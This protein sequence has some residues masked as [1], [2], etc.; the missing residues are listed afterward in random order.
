MHL[1]VFHQALKLS[2]GCTLDDGVVGHVQPSIL[3]LVEHLDLV[4]ALLYHAVG[5]LLE[6]DLEDAWEVVG[7]L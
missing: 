1:I 3:V 7:E 4:L 5:V 6:N 2:L